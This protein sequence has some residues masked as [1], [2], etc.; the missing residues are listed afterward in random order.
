MFTVCG[1]VTTSSTI[2]RTYMKNS[3]LSS[4]EILTLSV[5]KAELLTPNIPPTYKQ[6]IETRIEEIKRVSSTN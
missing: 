4:T 2:G 3:Q 1:K 6:C 5:L